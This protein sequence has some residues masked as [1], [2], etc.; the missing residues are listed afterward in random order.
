M[1][2]FKYIELFALSVELLGEILGMQAFNEEC[3]AR[4]IHPPH[5]EYDFQYRIREFRKRKK[6][7]FK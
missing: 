2:I 6:D 7:L 4:K 3:K 1:K 5:G